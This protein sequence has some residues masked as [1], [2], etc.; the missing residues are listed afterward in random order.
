MS[1]EKLCKKAPKFSFTFD[2]IWLSKKSNRQN[3]DDVT[4]SDDQLKLEMLKID[5]TNQ[6]VD[7]LSYWKKMISWKTFNSFLSRYYI[8]IIGTTHMIP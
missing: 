1:W 6:S 3:G 7:L 4:T 5:D 2:T 8:E